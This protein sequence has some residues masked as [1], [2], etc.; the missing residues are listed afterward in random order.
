MP[1]RRGTGSPVFTPTPTRSWESVRVSWIDPTETEWDLSDTRAPYFLADGVAGIGSIATTLTTDPQPRGGDRIRSTR[2][3]PRII[4]LPIFV[5]GDDTVAYIQQL[6]ALGDA[7]MRTWDDGPGSL[8]LRYPDGSERRIDGVCMA[9]PDDSGAG[10]MWRWGLTPVQLYC[11]DGHWYDPVEKVITRDYD[12]GGASFFAPYPRVSSGRTLG[13]TTLVNPGEVIAW[14]IWEITG[15]ATAIVAT[16]G[17]SGAVFT[18]TPAGGL[19]GGDTMT[20]TT[21]PPTVLDPAGDDA[22]SWL[23]IPG[24]TLWGLGRGETPV[25][26]AVSG[27][28]VGTRI[29]LRFRARYR[30]R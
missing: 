12:A 16:N 19:A 23:T 28:G 10:D 30:M 1:A 14:P 7:F 25:N 4:T 29:R 13:D 26:F 5:R 15:P 20:I 17:T 2:S 9:G 22:L 18:V 27:S 8:R 3:E 6:R 24:S 21:D 11:E